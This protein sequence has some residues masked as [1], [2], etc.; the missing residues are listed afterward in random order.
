MLSKIRQRKLVAR[1]HMRALCHVLTQLQLDLHIPATPLRPIVPGQELRCKHNGR[2][3]RW[4]LATGCATWEDV[5]ANPDPC[6]PRL[7]LSPDEGSP[8]FSAFQFM[9]TKGCLIHLARDELQP[10]LNRFIE[11][12]TMDRI[13]LDTL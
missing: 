11:H 2:P 6:R 1:D 4:S 9:A 8:M 10:G 13:C 7:V 12:L 3:F 5:S